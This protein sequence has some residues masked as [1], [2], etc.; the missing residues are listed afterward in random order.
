MKL[1]AKFDEDKLFFEIYQKMFLTKYCSTIVHILSV[2]YMYTE[3]TQ[4]ILLSVL[5]A[6][7]SCISVNVVVSQT[8]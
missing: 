6:Y 7:A 1:K 8:V 4:H 2:A 3:I 5:L